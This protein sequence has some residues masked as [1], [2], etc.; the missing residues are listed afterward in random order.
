MTKLG[1]AGCPNPGHTTLFNK[2]E[3]KAFENSIAD[4]LIKYEDKDG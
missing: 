3:S 2:A 1:H 4:E